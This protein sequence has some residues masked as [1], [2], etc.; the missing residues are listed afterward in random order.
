[1]NN[2]LFNGVQGPGATTGG[3]VAANYTSDWTISNGVVG[4][5]GQGQGFGAGYFNFPL[6]LPMFGN[7]SGNAKQ[8]STM[9]AKF[10]S[11]RFYLYTDNGNSSRG[12]FAGGSWNLGGLVGRWTSNWTYSPTSAY[13]Y[14]GFRC[15]LP[16]E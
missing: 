11:D 3:Q 4:G 14:I 5:T 16:A 2:F 13:A 7:D 15:A 9:T 1:M 10:H 8:I 6:G 12:L